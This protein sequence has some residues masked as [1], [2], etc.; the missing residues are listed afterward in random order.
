MNKRGQTLILF[1]ILIPILLG[2]CALVI[3]VG[4]IVSKSV[5]LKEV[6]K[7]IIRHS[8]LDTSE[9]EIR[10]MFLENDIP[11]NNLVIEIDEFRIHIQ[12]EYKIDSIFG[13]IIGI[14]EYEINV[15]L[16]G[17]WNDEEVIIE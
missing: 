14:Q 12:N 3:D 1:V 15:D 11:V 17:T 6:S 9:E 10:E 13:K 4:L 8:Y 2:L 5:E 16:T 7:S